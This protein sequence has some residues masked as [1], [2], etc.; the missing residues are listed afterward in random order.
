MATIRKRGEKYQVRIQIKG[1]AQVAKSFS[2]KADAEAFAKVTEAQIIR[3]AYI[4]RTEAERTNMGELFE[5]YAQE[6]SSQKR[7]AG[8]ELNRLERFK[9][10]KLAKLSPANVTGQV[11]AAWRDE[12][13]KSVTGPTVL[14]DMVLL[15]HVFAV[16]MREWGI[17]LQR[18]PVE[19]VRKP[20]HGKARDRVLNDDQ[21]KALLKAC[22][23]CQN[24][25]V[26]PVVL[27]ALET[28]ARRG[29]IL[30]LNWGD[31][32]LSRCTARVDG[33]TGGRVIPL[34]PLCVAMLRQLPR[35]L[36][37][38]VFP[39]TV[40]ALRQAYLRAVKRA[41]L[42]DWTFHDCRHDALTRMAGL[43]FS[44]LELSVD[45]R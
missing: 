42:D 16:A 31:V 7:G 33:K 37:G 24:P 5:R 36:D 22:S 20:A 19:L 25:W 3:G 45:A 29:E 10:S 14:R 44:I 41:G 18:N 12:R 21:R 35:S 6:I 39:I 32:D 4:N 43:G 28:G 11:I 23:R 27:F 1:Y 13:L 38:E 17:G 30:S 26:R 9:Q 8:Q 15:S 2:S 34:S 40:E